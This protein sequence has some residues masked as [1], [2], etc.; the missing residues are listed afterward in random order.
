MRRTHDCTIVPVTIDRHSD[1]RVNSSSDSVDAQKAS[2]E[3]FQFRIRPSTD[4]FD[5]KTTES[6]PKATIDARKSINH[7]KLK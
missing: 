3:L 2:Y 6:R 7:S 1:R 4:V 5:R